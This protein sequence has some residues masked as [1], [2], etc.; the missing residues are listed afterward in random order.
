L[1][2]EVFHIGLSSEHLLLIVWN[3]LE[4]ARALGAGLG[5]IDN[6]TASPEGFPWFL[7]TSGRRFWSAG[8]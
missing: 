2:D 1:W 4:I 5:A 6:A 8:G 3:V 7:S